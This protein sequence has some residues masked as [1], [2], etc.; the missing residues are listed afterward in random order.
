MSSQVSRLNG[1][2]CDRK[3]RPNT[4]LNLAGDFTRLKQLSI[5][6]AKRW[7]KGAF[8][9]YVARI[10]RDARWSAQVAEREF[11]HSHCTG[12]SLYCAATGRQ[13]LRAA[14]RVRCY[15]V[16]GDLIKAL[17]AHGKEKWQIDQRHCQRFA[18]IDTAGTSAQKAAERRW[19]PASWSVCQI[20]DYWPQTRVLFLRHVWR[21]RVAWEGLKSG[22]LHTLNQWRPKRVLIENAHF[23]QPLTVE[24]KGFRTELMSTFPG[25]TSESGRP[26]K[27]EHATALL[28]KLEKGEVFLPKFNNQWLSELESEWL[29][30]T[31]LDDETSDQID[32]A[33]FAARHAEK[34]ANVSWGLASTH[35]D[36]C[37]CRERWQTSHGAAVV[38]RGDAR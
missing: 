17:D 4:G 30:W 19:K 10:S 8:A 5:C 34:N 11:Y 1:N 12:Q 38:G 15:P 18:T 24:L 25:R 3:G 2:E 36:L 37:G 22:V 32:A 31:G 20:W 29:S 16:Q 33:A 7:S 6:E 14:A 28:N 13:R 9:G 27:V 26:G 23:G 35:S 21:D